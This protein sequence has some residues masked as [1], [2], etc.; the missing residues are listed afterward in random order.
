MGI[1]K[2]EQSNTKNV[3]IFQISC[4]LVYNQALCESA[5]GP[6]DNSN[7]AWFSWRHDQP[8]YYR[9]ETTQRARFHSISSFCRVWTAHLGANLVALDF[10]RREGLSHSANFESFQK[11]RH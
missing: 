4:R 2:V 10:I 9:G 11:G 7:G 3:K 1:A 8:A 5:Q 6:N